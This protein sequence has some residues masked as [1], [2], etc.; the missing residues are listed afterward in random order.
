MG[1]VTTSVV[2]DIEESMSRWTAEEL[3]AFFC[4]VRSN[5]NLTPPEDREELAKACMHELFWAYSSKGVA[6]V[7]QSTDKVKQLLYSNLPGRLKVNIAAPQRAKEIEEYGSIL[8]YEFLIREVARRLKI[9]RAQVDGVRAL[10]FY[11]VE[12]LF[13][14]A[15]AHMDARQR[16]TLLTSEIRLDRFAN[17]F[18]ETAYLPPATTL[19]ALAVA[20]GSG[21][22]VYLGATTALGFLSQ[23]VGVGL[24]FSAYTGL[25]STIA[26][27]IGPFGFFGAGAWLGLKMLG[28][29]WPRILRGVLHL[30]AMKAKYE[31]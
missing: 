16:H 12:D 14:R 6:H 2:S 19:A 17:A 5:E 4:C 21:F 24:P 22:G 1:T 10:E 15:G 7:K 13:L 8:S 31:Y 11:V 26:F 9:D 20:Q 27:L 18:P 28:P 23:A 25:T 3:Q 29:E 30:M